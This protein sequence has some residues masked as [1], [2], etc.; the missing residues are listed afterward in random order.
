MPAIKSG[1]G[2]ERITVG[3]YESPREK[4][5]ANAKIAQKDT[6]TGLPAH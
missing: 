1:Q 2:R 4:A 5:G 6:Q 3:L